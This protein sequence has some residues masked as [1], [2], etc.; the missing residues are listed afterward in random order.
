MKKQVIFIHGGGNFDS[1]KSYLSFLR[2]DKFDI[3]E[4]KK[5]KWKDSLDKDLGSKFEV[6]MP[7]MPNSSN[8]KYLEWKIWF[9]KLLPF[10]NQEVIFV[11]K[12]LGGIF[13]AKYLSENKCIQ[14]QEFRVEL[15]P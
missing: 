7:K 11:G 15:L 10:I 4:L 2:R 9:E 13:L 14:Q 6:L 1:Y 5:K 12:S 8:A 3:N